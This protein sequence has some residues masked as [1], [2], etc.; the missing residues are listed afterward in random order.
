MAPPCPWPGPAVL[1]ALVS[2]TLAEAAGLLPVLVP[3][4]RGAVP[5]PSLTFP[6]C[7]EQPRIS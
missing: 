2:V 5:F 7:Q 3:R 6:A 1:V 4:G